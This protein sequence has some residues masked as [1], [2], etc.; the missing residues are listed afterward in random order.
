MVARARPTASR[1]FDVSHLEATSRDC[2]TKTQTGAGPAGT[3]VECD[4]Y[5]RQGNLPP[6][7]VAR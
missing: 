2:D 7:S 3:P 5:T 1:Q 4:R 6:P